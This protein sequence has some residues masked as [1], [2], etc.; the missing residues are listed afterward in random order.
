MEHKLT[1][2]QH[3]IDNNP[4]LLY[5]KGEKDAPMCRFSVDVVR[6]LKSMNVDFET[7]NVLEDDVLR[8]GIKIFSDWPTIPQLYVRGEF[9]GGRDIIMELKESGELAEILTV[10]A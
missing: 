9:I 10:G 4:I 6:T 2:I 3:D 5:M 1:E 8:E 7:R